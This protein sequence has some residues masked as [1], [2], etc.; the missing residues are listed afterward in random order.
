MKQSLQLRLGQQLSMT[1]QLQQAIRLLQL[2]SLDLQTEIQQAIENN[3]LLE[4]DDDNTT[5]NNR[6]TDNSTQSTGENPD[7]EYDQ[8][9]QTT[10]N[11]AEWGRS[12]EYPARSPGYNSDDKS[13][14]FPATGEDLRGHL[15]SQANT[16][17][18]SDSDR[19]IADALINAIDDN[20]YLSVGAD[21]IC[22][23][24][25]EDLEITNA[26][27]DVVLNIIQHFDPTGVGARNL[28]E[29]L[30]LQLEQLPA[31]QERQLALQ[32]VRDCFDSLCR[33][34]YAR[35]SKDSGY[36]GEVIQCAVNTIQTLSP[37]PGSRISVMPTEYIMPDILVRRIKGQWQT[38]LNADFSPQLRINDYYAAL[39]RR[40]DDSRDNQFL[41]NNLQEARWFLKSLRNRNDTLLKVATLIVRQQQEFFEHGEEHMKPLVLRDIAEAVDMHESTISRVTTQKYMHT[42]RGTYELKYFFSSHVNTASGGECSSTAIRA[43]IKKLIASENDRKPLSD[44]KL[45]QLLEQRGIKVARRTVAKYRESLLIPPSNERRLRA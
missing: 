42:P 19:L 25:P 8:F 22:S 14:D 2:S 43:I 28:R 15:Y 9:Q 26:E 1:P 21:E 39:I 18:L 23:I 17:Q 3:P 38:M 6:Q 12:S 20:G 36:P 31:N 45:A 29:C 40:S 5:T 34:D 37:R 13:V 4:F 10:P 16:M 35:I 41:K 30:L 33:K 27:I 24:L 7:A 11:E 44:S 32:I